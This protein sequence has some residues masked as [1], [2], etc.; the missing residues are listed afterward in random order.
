MQ[1]TYS[2]KP[3]QVVRKWHLIDAQGQTLGRLATQI[4][5]KLMGK[6]Q[7]EYTPHVD[8]GDFV[9]V[10]NAAQVAVSGKKLTD[11]LYRWYTGFVGG[12]KTRTFAEMR[13]KQPEKIIQLAVSGMLP[14]N[15]LRDRRLARLK[16][17]AG[18]EHNHQSQLA[19]KA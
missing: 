4:A 10:I 1:K 8:S 3:A 12:L 17:Y 15:K 16:I 18:S 14:K 2:Q 6:D 5:T 9:V 19:A 7:P 11:K 13:E